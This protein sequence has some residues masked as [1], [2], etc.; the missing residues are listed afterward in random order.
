MPLAL[1][2]EPTAFSLL[3]SDCPLCTVTNTA[4]DTMILR[5]GHET[6]AKKFHRFQDKDARLLL[7]HE[8]HLREQLAAVTVTLPPPPSEAEP[9]HKARW[10][11][12][13]LFRSVFSSDE[14]YNEAVEPEERI[15]ALK[16]RNGALG[17]L[18]AAVRLEA[19][20]S[21]HTERGK[22]RGR[23]QGE[24]ESAEEEARLTSVMTPT[25]QFNYYESALKLKGYQII[26]PTQTDDTIDITEDAPIE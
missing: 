15:G 20:L 17:H 1:T 23:R 22:V 13:E 9:L 19:D 2:T 12:R 25:E 4:L 14:Q 21:G 16:T 8:K 3:C 6:T 26:K 10:V 18:L 7:E 11:S 5:L 24:R